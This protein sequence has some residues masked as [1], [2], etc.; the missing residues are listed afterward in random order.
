MKDVTVNV[1]VSVIN[2][3]R[4]KILLR[5]GDVIFISS[6]LVNASLSLRKELVRRTRYS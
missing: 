3:Y 2:I 6:T 1:N 5:K 4:V